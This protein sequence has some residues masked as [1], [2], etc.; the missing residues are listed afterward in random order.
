MSNEEWGLIFRGSEWLFLALI[1]RV[2]FSVD[3][4]TCSYS[5]INQ[6]KKFLYK[7]S[8]AIGSVFW[9]VIKIFPLVLVFL[10]AKHLDL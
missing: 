4:K 2:K 10:K 7:R 5:F 6:G 8:K 9:K 1:L 3:L